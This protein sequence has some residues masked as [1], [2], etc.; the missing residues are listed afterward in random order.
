MHELSISSAIVE[1]ACRHADGR[2]VMQVDVRVGALRQ[3]VPDSL[4]FY[5]DI[6]SRE[7]LC[8][9]AR[10]EMPLGSRTLVRLSHR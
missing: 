1:T 5:F 6:V 10:L 8:A 9:G 7:T 3:V 2:Q 4:D